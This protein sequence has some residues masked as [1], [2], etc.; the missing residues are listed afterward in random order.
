MEMESLNEVEKLALKKV[1]IF[2]QSLLRYILRSY[3]AIRGKMA[4]LE[5]IQLW[6]SSYIGNILGAAAFALLI[7]TT[8]LFAESSVN[9]FL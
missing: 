1:K 5:V 4:W 6:I 7:F 3:A 8:G 9:D 2:R